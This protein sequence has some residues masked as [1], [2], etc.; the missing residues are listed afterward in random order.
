MANYTLRE[1]TIGAQLKFMVEEEVPRVKNAL[2]QEM[3]VLVSDVPDPTSQRCEAFDIFG[4]FF[5]AIANVMSDSRFETKEKSAFVIT[6]PDNPS[7]IIFNCISTCNEEGKNYSYSMGFDKNNLSGIK[8]EQT[9][10][11]EE[12]TNQ[13]NLS[14]FN[15]VNNS[16][17][18]THRMSILD[19]SV[20]KKVVKAA[21][22]CLYNWLDVQAVEG[23]IVT[24]DIT[25]TPFGSFESPITPE[26]YKKKLITVAVAAVEI[27]KDEKTMSVVF[28]DDL[29]AIAKGNNDSSVQ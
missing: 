15:F 12:Y 17:Q 7:E 19:I 25:D 6:D 20:M 18:K 21:I 28:G 2:G 22:K 13:N 24:L 8:P 9:Y 5:T 10:S 1:T 14:F 27:I 26:E 23:D 16:L 11:W 3:T 29:K 4:S